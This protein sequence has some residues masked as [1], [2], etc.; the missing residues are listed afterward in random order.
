VLVSRH[1]SEITSGSRSSLWLYVLPRALLGAVLVFLPLGYA[2]LSTMGCDGHGGQNDRSAIYAL[3]T[4]HAGQTRFRREDLDHDGKPD[5]ASLHE[6]EG[7][8]ILEV[9]F[10]ELHVRQGYSFEVW[11]SDAPGHPWWGKASPTVLGT[12]GDRYF[13]VNREGAIYFSRSDLP[14][15]LDET[16]DEVTLLGSSRS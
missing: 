5:F 11:R 4:L 15:P 6:L 3:Q 12:T 1:P 10:G 13:Y 7:L 2:F 9:G 14:L 8:E 16:S